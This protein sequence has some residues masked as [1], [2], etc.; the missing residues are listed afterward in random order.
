VVLSVMMIFPCSSGLFR[1][2]V[3]S[4]RSRP[5]ARSAEAEKK[6]RTGA[7]GAVRPQ[8]GTDDMIPCHGTGSYGGTDERKGGK[9]GLV[10]VS[11]NSRGLMVSSVASLSGMLSPGA[12]HPL[13][14]RSVAGPDIARSVHRRPAYRAA[15]DMRRAGAPMPQA[16]PPAGVIPG[17]SGG[18]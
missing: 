15:Q 16:V 18:C 6:Q 3:T 10:R 5:R 9:S 4:E 7:G 12:G 2:L 14:D 17:R 1:A 13:H 11:R 8:G